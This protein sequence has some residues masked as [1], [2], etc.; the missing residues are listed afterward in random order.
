MLVYP[1]DLSIGGSQINAIDLAAAVAEAGHDVIVYGI[2]GPLVSYIEERG[3]RYVPARPLKYRPAPSRIVQ[4]AALVRSER[5]D[6]IHAYE[7]PTCL[8]AYYGAGLLLNVPLLCTVL[9]MQVM[10]HVPASVPLIMGT[11]DLAIEARKTHRGQVWVLEP[12]ID[13]E[14]DTPLLD[15][16]AFRNRHG[17]ADEEFLVVTVSRLAIDLKL[18]ALVRAIDAADILAGSYPLRLILLGDGPAREALTTR[19]AAVN[20]RHGREIVMLP[21]ADLDP[22]SAYAAADLVIGMG[23]SALRALAIARPLIVQGEQAFSEIFEP[24]TV[25]L[26]LRQGFYGLADGAAGAGRLAAQIEG[27]IKD[28]ARRTALGRFGREMVTKRFGLQR[29]ANLQLDIYRQV[30]TEPPRRRLIE[31]MRSVRLA[32]MLEIANH[33]PFEKRAKTSRE[34]EVLATVR[35]GIWPPV[36]RD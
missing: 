23:S 11:S 22:R 5:I 6:L 33:D 3:L 19:A 28:P 2:P 14:R 15:G 17:V 27:L 30:L 9:S 18:D 29:A 24:S 8:D 34:Q 7:W 16:K 20:R 21:G 12:P 10:P 31:A 4:I 25:E 32:L 35:S 36:L 1:H 26:F 13:V